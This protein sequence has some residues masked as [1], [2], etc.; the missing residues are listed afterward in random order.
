MRVFWAQG[1]KKWQFLDTLSKRKKILTD[2][3]KALSFFGIFV[4][5]T[6]SF[7]CFG[8]LLAFF[9]L[10]FFF[11]FVFL[12]FVFFG[13]FKG[14]V[15]WPKG[16]PHLALNPPYFFVFVFLLFFVVF[17]GGFKGQVR[18]PKGPPHLALNPPYFLFVFFGFL[19]F[20]FALLSLFFLIGK[21]TCFPPRKGHFCL[22]SMFLFLSPLT[23]FGL[24]LFLSLSFSVSLFLLSFFLPSCLSSLLYFC[25]LFLSLFHFSFFFA[26]VSWKEKHEHFQLQFLFFLKY[27]FFLLVSCLAFLFQIPFSYLCFFLILS[28]VFCSTSMFLVSKRTNWKA[29]KNKQ[30]QIAT[31]RFFFLWTCVLQNV[32][33]YRF[34]PLCCQILVHVQ[35]TL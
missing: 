26:F 11:F 32:K 10:F 16:P 4:F 12:C 18:W 30:K 19:F 6:F 7:F 3:W 33:S 15:R 9:V 8:F 27:F 23:F 14:Q 22:F 2:N 1:V 20:F 5:F 28:Y 29:Q 35:K 24:P 25:F 17:F 13:G 31:K 34:L 21:K